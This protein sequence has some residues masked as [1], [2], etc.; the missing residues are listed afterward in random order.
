MPVPKGAHRLH[1]ISADFGTENLAEAISPV[2]DRLMGNVDPALMKQ[3]FDVSQGEGV[4]DVHHHGQ[5]DDLW[6]SFEVPKEGQ[7]AHPRTLAGLPSRA[8]DI[9]LTVPFLYTQAWLTDILGRI[10]DHKIAK[11]NELLPW[12]YDAKAT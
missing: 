9:I 6:R 1:S 12:C 7:G 10:A 4:S 5:T 2:A 11:L 3:V 8:T